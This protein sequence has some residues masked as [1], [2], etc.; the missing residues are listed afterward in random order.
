MGL[1]L[2]LAFWHRVHECLASNF[3]LSSPFLLIT[4]WTHIWELHSQ[5]KESQI[6][7][8]SHPPCSV[9]FPVNCRSQTL[10]RGRGASHTGLYT[11]LV[12]RLC[13][14]IAP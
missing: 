3:L 12:H 5:G 6:S 1:V 7:K 4:E 14:T 8:N 11:N 13:G 9:M 10:L 2:G